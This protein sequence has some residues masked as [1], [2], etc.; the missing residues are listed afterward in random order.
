MKACPRPIRPQHQPSRKGFTLI[1]LLVVISIIAVLISLITPA[2]QSA[3]AAARRLQCLN[4]Q[5]NLALAFSNFANGHSG[6]FPYLVDPVGTGA[7]STSQTAIDTPLETISG[8]P[9]Q[10]LDQLDNAAILRQTRVNAQNGTST[11]TGSISPYVP[12][13]TLKFFQCPDDQN[14]LNVAQGLSYQVN[15]GLFGGGQTNSGLTGFP[16]AAS[17][18]I[19]GT[20]TA[21]QGY[22]LGVI[23][24]KIPVGDRRTTLD[25]LNQGD[26]TE[27]TLLLAENSAGG[28][29]RSFASYNPT[30]LAFG[31]NLGDVTPSGTI[32]GGTLAGVSSVSTLGKS[33][34]NANL[35]T[36]YTRPS[37]NHND[38]IHV[39]FT[40]GRA[41][42]IN[43][44]IDSSVYI[45]L[46]TPNGQR[47]N[48]G[49][50]DPGA[51]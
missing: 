27:Y 40:S 28:S 11:G 17:T 25:Y 26:G 48:E 23:F 46:L 8:W 1:E 13:A 9:V 7:T 36:N 33:K 24:Q 10:L 16:I 15:G 6:G 38:I 45:R 47:M 41:Q 34:P 2:V 20:G 44:S 31:L 39:A 14:N 19:G 5:K 51:L 4:N 35:G 37:S 18:A 50:L 3:R 49:I 29:F 21:T 22:Q 43:E 42:T 12:T 30:N 32:T